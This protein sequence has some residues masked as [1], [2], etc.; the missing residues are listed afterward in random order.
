MQATA[1]WLHTDFYDVLGVTPDATTKDIKTAY[2]KLARTAHPDAN[3]DDPTAE[4]RFSDIAKA[5]EVLRDDDSRAEY[6]EL[7]SRPRHTPFDRGGFE[8]G[9]FDGVQFDMSDLFDMFGGARGQGPHQ[10][11]HHTNPAD[12]P[13]R[14]ADLTA[15][16]QL[17]FV[18]AVNGMT[19]TLDLDGRSVT[20][21]IP[22]GVADGQT[23]RLAGKGR[24]GANGGPDGDL[25]IDISV[26]SHPTFARAGRNLKVTVPI[27]YTDAVLGGQMRV[28]TLDGGQVTVKIPAGTQ[29]G[30]T[31]RVPGKGVPGASKPGDLLA[32]VTIDVPTEVSDAD[33]ELLRQLS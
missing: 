14:G 5:Y 27:S 10:A 19:T 18:D 31:F 24:P 20:T 29:V 12:W 16:L 6:D 15:G 3:P 28:P 22:A 2:R 9:G 30:R 17:D 21:R 8:A 11:R 1:E 32:T 23:I 13:R 26:R 7:R 4:Q 25:F 33:A